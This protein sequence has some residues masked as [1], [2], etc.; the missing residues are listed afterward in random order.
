MSDLQ[1]D[2]SRAVTLHL[3][4]RGWCSG[5]CQRC[6]V[7]FLARPAGNGC[8]RRGC[9]SGLLRSCTAGLRP[10]FPEQVWQAVSTHFANA[11]FVMTN[12]RDIA[13]P[14][15]RD[16]QFVG[17]GLQVFE[18]GIERGLDPPAMPLFVPQPVIRLNYWDAVGVS[19]ATSTSF[20]N[21][22]TEHA[23]SS[24]TEFR[25]HLDVWLDLLVK[26]GIRL[27]DTTIIFAPERWRG[28]PYSGPCLRVMVSGTEVGDAILIDEGGAEATGYLPIADFS[29]GLERIVAVLNPR[30]RYSLFLGALPEAVL[31]ENE[32]A[33]DRIRTAMLM[34][35]SGVDPSSR[36]HGRHV[37]R[38][39]SDALRQGS[40]LDFAA[41]IVHAHGY[42][43]QFITTVRGLHECQRILEAERARARAIEVVRMCRAGAPHPDLSAASADEACRRLLAGVGDIESIARCAAAFRNRTH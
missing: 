14:G 30:L 8:R 36:G 39:V 29:F 26:L 3:E 32:R 6:G 9:D 7:S 37:R 33:I 18:D 16:T 24:L 41:A 27:D 22:C 43:S 11:Q 12:R 13:N 20:V 21:L 4:S 25:R 5:E 28:G 17:A 10:R 38:A 35:M 34:C 19:D 23:Q 15:G 1:T 2:F 40:V 42:W 31:P